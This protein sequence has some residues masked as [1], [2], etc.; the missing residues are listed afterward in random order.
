MSN[1]LSNKSILGSL[2]VTGDT[3]VSGK[4]SVNAA[5]GE[6]GGEMFLAKPLSNTTLDG[7]I[8]IDVYQNKLRFFEQGGSARGFYIDITSGI[9]GAGSNLV[10]GGGS[11]ISLTSL[12]AVSPIVYNNTTGQFSLDKIDGGTP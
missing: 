4:L 11:G 2:T 9:G 6:E 12:S 1:T 3:S 8:T 5:S 10:T 7:G